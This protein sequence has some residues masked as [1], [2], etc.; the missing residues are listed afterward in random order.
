MDG[1]ANKLSIQ[2]Q[3]SYVKAEA[4]KKELGVCIFL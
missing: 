3:S 2:A 1:K 4:W